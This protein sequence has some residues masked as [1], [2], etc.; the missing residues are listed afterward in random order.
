MAKKMLFVFNLKAGTSAVRG[1]AA[2][3]INILTRGGYDV[4]AHP[5]QGPDDMERFVAE[6]GG[7]FDIVVT[8][9]G[10]CSLNDTINGLMTLED[11]PPLGYIP[12]GTMNDFAASH[13]IN[14]N[15]LLAAKDVVNGMEVYTD[16]GRFNGRYFS[17]VAAF[18]AF[19]DVAYDTPQASKNIFGKGA[20]FFEGIRRL[21]MI[22]SQHLKVK[23][24]TLETEGDYIY[25][26]ASNALSVGGF[27]LNKMAAVS[28][29]DG[30]FELVL[31]KKGISA[32]FNAPV[33]LAAITQDIEHNRYLEYAKT[34]KVVLT[35]D[36]PVSWTLDGEFGGDVHEATIECVPRKL[37]II[38]PQSEYTIGMQWS[39]RRRSVSPEFHPDRRFRHLPQ[40]QEQ[41]HQDAHARIAPPK[42]FFGMHW[43][44][45][46]RV[47][48]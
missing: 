9:G 24:D 14:G 48:K 31:V 16:I 12:T 7:D 30:C 1:K 27:S 20:Y 22:S 6:R 34:S 40:E 47:H 15:M 28:M 10:D 44:G 32:F 42:S 41:E 21:P 46:N 25:G 2:D 5:S 4:T 26:M 11:P 23:C 36:E 18:G 3:I 39:Q 19:T 43:F 35:S 37:K 13:N 33:M 8:C 29:D 17:Y 45:R 38:V